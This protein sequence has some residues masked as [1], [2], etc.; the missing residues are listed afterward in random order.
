LKVPV[1]AALDAQKVTVVPLMVA[2]I[3]AGRPLTAKVTVPVKPLIAVTVIVTLLHPPWGT[4]RDDGLTLKEK[5]GFVPATVKLTAL[6]ATPLTETVTFTPPA[7][8]LGTVTVSEVVVAAV[9]VPVADPKVTV[10][11]FA[12][13]LKLVPAMVID[14]PGA[15]DAGLIELMVGAL[16]PPPPSG[17]W[18][19]ASM[20]C[21]WLLTMPLY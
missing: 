16:E 10:F 2:V 9:T 12:V 21:F 20:L 5:S 3:P 11:A 14:A 4:V 13:V 7:A 15:A 19:V 1:V 17:N 18:I 8:I 6:L